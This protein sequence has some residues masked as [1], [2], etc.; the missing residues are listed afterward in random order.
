MAH[1]AQIK[2]CLSVKERFPHL[3]DNVD[4]LDCGSHNIN[5]DNRYLFTNSRYTG[6]DIEA[7]KNVDVVS[8]MHDYNALPGSFDVIISTEMLEHDMYY[9][10]SLAHMIKLL[11]GGGLLII[12][13]GSH[14]REIHG[15]AGFREGDSPF[16]VKINGW[17]DYFHGLSDGELLS[18]LNA[19]ERFTEYAA[20]IERNDLDLN[21]WGI[22]KQL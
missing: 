16:T 17:C 4:V 7:G 8:L 9:R 10:Q 1:P 6:L 20:T 22:K 12:T 11:K 18:I 21:F 19:N 2:F 5:G 15:V 14:K 13:C 3:F